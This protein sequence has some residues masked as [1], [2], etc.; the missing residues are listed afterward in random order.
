LAGCA[1]S[2]DPPMQGDHTAT[3][4]QTDLQRCQKQATATATRAANA[5]PQSALRAIFASDEPE[6]ADMRSC[7]ESRGYHLQS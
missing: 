7:M 1:S 3:R 5:T 2:Y 4:Y 6:R